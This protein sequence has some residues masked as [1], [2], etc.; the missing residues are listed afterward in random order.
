MTTPS[1]ETL[2]LLG[3][4]VFLV[5]SFVAATV[6]FTL[7]RRAA[8]LQNTQLLAAVADLAQRLAALEARIDATKLSISELGERFAQA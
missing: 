1:L 6:A 2:L 5:L 4:S 8:A 3:S 7:G